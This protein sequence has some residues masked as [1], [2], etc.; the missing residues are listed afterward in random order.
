MPIYDNGICA[1]LIKFGIIT[2][3]D[4]YSDADDVADKKRNKDRPK[5]GSD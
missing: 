1:L 5:Y 2:T 4:G 3:P